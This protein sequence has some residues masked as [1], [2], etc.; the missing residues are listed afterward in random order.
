MNRRLRACFTLGLILTGGLTKLCHGA[1][2]DSLETNPTITMHVYNYADVSPKALIEHP[3]LAAGLTN[4]A[5]LYSKQ[6][7]YG[8]AEPLYRRSLAIQ[9]KV[10]GA[11]HPD[12]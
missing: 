10:L 8:Q 4:L 6:G 3:D 5:L 1:P 12:L 2:T 11:D 9:E 7:K